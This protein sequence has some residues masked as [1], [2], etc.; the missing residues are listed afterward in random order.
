MN[1]WNNLDVRE[2]WLVGTALGLVLMLAVVFLLVRP[3][4]ENKT[5]AERAQVNAQS[6]LALIQK[7]KGL[8]SGKSTGSGTLKM[9][10][11]SLFQTAQ[12][13]S[14]EMT[15]LNPEADGAMKVWFEESSSQQVY[16]F[17]VDTTSKYAATVSSAQFTRKKDGKVSVVLTFRP[18]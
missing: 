2:R 17:I 8:L 7:H 13:N 4:M 1:Y 6:D 12:A 3:I 15:R 14:L 18:S 10:R 5:K 9:D 11:N 16:K